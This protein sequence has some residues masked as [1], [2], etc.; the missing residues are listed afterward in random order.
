MVRA[1]LRPVFPFACLLIT[2]AAFAAEPVRI[3]CQTTNGA[4]GGNARAVLINLPRLEGAQLS[5]NCM[6]TIG[7]KVAVGV[8]VISGADRGAEQ[9]LNEEKG[10]ERYVMELADGKA[11]TSRTTPLTLLGSEEQLFRMKGE[12]FGKSGMEI[13]AA[14]VRVSG[15]NVF[16][17]AVYPASRA[18]TH[19]L[20]ATRLF[21][22]ARV[23]IDGTAVTGLR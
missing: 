2:T 16:F 6:Q 13:L 20:A 4:S 21:E 1:V 18:N 14:R 23:L 22:Q 12:L 17:L 3:D 5:P 10:A 15:H 8:R 11:V 9:L 19:R 7:E